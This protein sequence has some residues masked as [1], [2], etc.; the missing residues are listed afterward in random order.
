MKKNYMKPTMR[1]VKMQHRQHILAGSGLRGVK[2][3]NNS[4]NINWKDGGFVDGED[5]Y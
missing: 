3:V 5:D 4:E 1:V 2:S